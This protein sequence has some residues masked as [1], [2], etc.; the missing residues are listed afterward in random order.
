MVHLLLSACGWA[1]GVS[2]W[3]EHHGWKSEVTDKK[4]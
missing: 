1:E 3:K 2:E 4:D